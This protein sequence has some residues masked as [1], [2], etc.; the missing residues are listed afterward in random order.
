MRRYDCV[1]Y[2]LFLSVLLVC[3]LWLVGLL[4]VVAWLCG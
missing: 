2:V 1:T 4:T 3:S